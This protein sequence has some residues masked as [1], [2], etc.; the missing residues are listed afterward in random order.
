MNQLII[1]YNNEDLSPLVVNFEK[2]K[3]PTTTSNKGLDKVK[4][5]YTNQVD[6][7]IYRLLEYFQDNGIYNPVELQTIKSIVRTKSLSQFSNW[8]K[9]K[10]RA[11]DSRFVKIIVG[12]GDTRTLNP[13]IISYLNL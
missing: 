5:H 7:G 4:K 9:G 3:I 2:P 6:T 11:P 10:G 13:E 8:P 1:N 12:T